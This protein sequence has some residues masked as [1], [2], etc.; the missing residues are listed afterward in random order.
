M[1]KTFEW[2][3]ECGC[4]YCTIKYRGETF[5]G[6]ATC[7][8]EDMDFMSERTG[9]FIAET[10]ATIK[11]LKYIKKYELKPELKSLKYVYNVMTSNKNFNSK[12]T[13]ARIM[14]KHI[15][16]K[17][18]EIEALNSYLKNGIEYLQEYIEGKD[19]FYKKVR[20]ARAKDSADKNN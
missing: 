6:A 20:A 2:K 4:A 7:H 5:I 13:E 14:R 12:S 3:D 8:K 15:H 10:R 17:E 16:M 1:K 9:L 11:L 18:D 19:D